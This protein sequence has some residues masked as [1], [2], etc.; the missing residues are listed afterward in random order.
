L[1][2][3]ICV[4]GGSKSGLNTK[5]KKNAQIVGQ[6]IA[7]SNFDIIYGG[8]EK[9]IMG[10]VASSGIR[11]GAKTIGIIPEFLMSKDIVNSSLPNHFN[12]ELIL[13]KT[14]HQRK[15]M[16]YDKSD[17][18]VILPGG[19]GTLDECFEVLTWCQLD[20]I[21]NKNVG[22]LNLENY[23]N[24]LILLIKH[25]IEEE[26]MTPDNLNYFEEIKNFNEF[27]FFLKNI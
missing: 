2:K 26:F 4:F 11:F 5:N 14:M 22:I 13:T 25:L 10:A 9:G 8:G 17:G 3:K 24:P 16:M 19:I 27:N 7:E 18:F 6:M 21:K 15:K 23:W 1:K 20:Q 12:S